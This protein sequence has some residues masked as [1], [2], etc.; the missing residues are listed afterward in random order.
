MLQNNIEGSRQEKLVSLDGRSLSLEQV[1]AVVRYNSKAEL[2]SHARSLIKDSAETILYTAA[3]LTLE[4]QALAIPDNLPS[5]PTSA[6]QEDQNDNSTTATRHLTEVISN[7]SRI[8]AIELLAAAQVLDLRIQLIPQAKAALEATA[9]HTRIRELVPFRA[10]DYPL[11]AD[12]ETVAELVRS[13][14]LVKYVN[15]ALAE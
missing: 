10:E 6:G 15:L 9:V 11:A 13:G 2:A 1:E 12:I 4:K 8:L 7:L 14:D 5:I 3:S